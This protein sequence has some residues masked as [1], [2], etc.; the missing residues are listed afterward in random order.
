MKRHVRRIAICLL[1]GVIT[2]IAVAWTCAVWVNVGAGDTRLGWHDAQGL[3]KMSGWALTRRDA[4]GA[5]RVVAMVRSSKPSPPTMSFHELVPW[6]S[7]LPQ[8]MARQVAEAK[9]EAMKHDHPT[10]FG[11]VQPTV[12]Y[13]DGRGWPLPVLRCLWDHGVRPIGPASG[14]VL[15]GGIQLDPWQPNVPGSTNIDHQRALPYW[16]IWPGFGINTI[17][18]A[19]LLW[20]LICGPFV[21]RRH[22]RRKRG[23]C[24][25][26]GYDLRHADHEACPECGARR[27]PIA[28]KPTEEGL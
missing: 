7:D 10:G 4:F 1:L 16:P 13:E 17:F 5:T 23:L 12:L 22:I 25:A 8:V 6:W 24:V 28:G 27:E 2:T 9:I 21:L 26:C 18:Y 19:A 14:K 3:P 15:N 11:P 20:L